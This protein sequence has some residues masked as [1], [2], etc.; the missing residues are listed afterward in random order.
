MGDGTRRTWRGS[1][2]RPALDL[3]TGSD[4]ET[5]K[6][7]FNLRCCPRGAVLFQVLFGGA[8]KVTETELFSAAYPGP[9][10]GAGI[11]ASINYLNHSLK[12]PVKLFPVCTWTKAEPVS[13]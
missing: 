2:G 12:D 7:W 11:A 13:R 3:C 1:S 5:P 6:Q 10:Q 8:V 9:C 4:K